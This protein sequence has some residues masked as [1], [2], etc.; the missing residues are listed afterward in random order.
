MTRQYIPKV[1]DKVKLRLWEHYIRLDEER[2]RSQA[3]LPDA[4]SW[5][6][7]LE[8]SPEICR[9]RHTSRALNAPDPAW[10]GDVPTEQVAA[11]LG[12]KPVYEIVCKDKEQ[13]DKVVSEWFKRGIH[14]WT[15][16]NMSSSQCGGKAFTPA[17]NGSGGSPHWQY[18]GN[19][20]ETIPAELCPM[21]FTVKWLE[22]WEPKLPPTEEKAASEMLP[23][24]D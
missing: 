20:I 2:A 24:E 4:W 12:W 18:T 17:E 5:F 3:R 21:L 15:N 22:E 14:V 19:P 11:P 10:E 16:H 23:E 13:A 6:D 7:V 1:G 8:V 9:L